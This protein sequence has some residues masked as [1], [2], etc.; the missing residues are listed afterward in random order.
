M[1]K[2]ILIVVIA[3]VILGLGG[4]LAYTIITMNNNKKE[5]EEQLADKQVE[6]DDLQIVVDELGE[7]ETVYKI[8]QYVTSGTQVTD[9][10]IEAVDIPV[11]M[12]EGYVHDPEEVVG[13][14]WKISYGPDT[15]LTDEMTYEVP[16]ERDDRI[17]DVICDRQPVG[18][19][20]GDI[21]DIRITFPDGQ[22]FLLLH[23]KLVADIY[24]NAMRLVV[25]EKDILVYA[26]AESDWARFTK[27][28]KAGTSVKMYCTLYVEAGIQE[29]DR[30]YPIQTTL[31]DGKT[32]EGSILWV[33]AQDENLIATEVDLSDWLLIDRLEF[34]KALINYDVYRKAV[35]DK[36][37]KKVSYEV[38]LEGGAKAVAGAK[39]TRDKQYEDAVKAYEQREAEAAKAEADAA[40]AAEKAAK[41][42]QNKNNSSSD[43]SGEA[44]E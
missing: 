30:Y 7:V 6:I 24:G 2:I 10:Q 14:Y 3:L 12:A 23:K 38:D 1:K 26:S 28:G 18:F 31:P 5:Y 22:D 25:S 42:N 17:L 29:G 39:T 32:F 43:D 36:V 13:K 40:K 20:P 4:G 9:E 15:L 35:T 27:S 41:K 34:E 21:V 33:A 16:I 44:A 37:T 11:A 19:K 8:S